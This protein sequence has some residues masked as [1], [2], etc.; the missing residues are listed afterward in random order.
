M[1]VEQ[2]KIEDGLNEFSHAFRVKLIKLQHVVLD[3][4]SWMKDAKICLSELSHFALSK[5]GKSSAS[6]TTTPTT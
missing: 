1:Y 4:Q 5:P 2:E 6:S 3:L